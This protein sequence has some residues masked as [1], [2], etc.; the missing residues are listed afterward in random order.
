MRSPG[1]RVPV[2]SIAMHE[3]PEQHACTQAILDM[4]ILGDVFSIVQV[5]KG[6]IVY[7]QVNRDCSH[8]QQETKNS[9]ASR[10]VFEQEI[11]TKPEFPFWPQERHHSTPVSPVRDTVKQF[12]IGSTPDGVP[13]PT[14]TARNCPFAA[15]FC[16]TSPYPN[17]L[18]DGFRCRLDHDPPIPSVSVAARSGPAL[19]RTAAASDVLPPAVASSSAHV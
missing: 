15:Y 10:R 2:Q 3:R 18:I 5:R 13:S 9:R 14:S 11:A 17:Q 7:R 4:R 6:V 8:R 16:N 19:P 1:Q 12:V